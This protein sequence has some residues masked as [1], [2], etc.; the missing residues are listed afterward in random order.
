MACPR[1][2]GSS[3]SILRYCTALCKA[4]AGAC[5]FSRLPKRLLQVLHAAPTARQLLL[6]ST[7][8]FR[9]SFNL[10]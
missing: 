3:H 1:A 9:Y 4:I 6:Q 2:A 8:Q 7:L 10:L 5:R